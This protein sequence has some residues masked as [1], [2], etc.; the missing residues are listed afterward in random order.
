M[1]TLDRV[2]GLANPTMTLLSGVYPDKLKLAPSSDGLRL[3]N[4]PTTNL[5]LWNTLGVASWAVP[6]AI[7][8]AAIANI[9]AKKDVDKARNKSDNLLLASSRPYL[10]PKKLSD[11]KP[12][13]SEDRLS[14]IDT[15][16][17]KISKA[18]SSV[19]ATTL[20][21]ALPMMAL[22]AAYW[23][24]SKLTNSFISDKIEGDLEAERVALRDLQDAEDLERLKLLGMVEDE[25][26]A[27]SERSL[28]KRANGP[29]LGT[30]V[31]G[32][33]TRVGDMFHGIDP[34]GAT[35]TLAWDAHITPLLAAAALLAVGGGTYLSKRDRDHKKVQL[36]TKKLLGENRLHDP[37]Q[38]SIDL[39]TKLNKSN[40]KSKQLQRIE[41]LPTSEDSIPTG[42]LENSKEKDA[43]FA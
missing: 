41:G 34:A 29:S 10:T 27:E 22:P 16:A 21:G 4:N 28:S 15:D 8:T 37:A 3:A 6:L 35:K 13:I 18:A 1:N 14:K 11:K 26:P 12:S 5:A 32:L 38:L 17:L 40:D 24:A 39:P 31:R 30:M 19:F 43:L 9:K 23:L 20:K 2:V 7:A 25:D 33:T 42:I 36:L